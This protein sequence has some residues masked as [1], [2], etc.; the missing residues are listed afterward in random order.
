MRSVVRVSALLIVLAMSGLGARATLA[1]S[2]K[3]SYNSNATIYMTTNADPTFDT[4]APTAF[5]ESDIINKLIFSGVTKWALNGA[6]EGDLATHW[7]VSKNKLV[8]TFYLRK[9][10]KW[11][12]GKPFTSADVVYTYQDVVL[13]KSTPT[14]KASVY[15]AV[16]KVKADG[17]YKVKFIL[18]T[19]FSDLPEYL[20]YYAPVLPKHALSGSNPFTNTHFNKVHPIG[21]GPYIMKKYTPGES[22]TLVRNPH[23]FGA[24]PKIKTI[25]FK[26]IPTTTTE[27]S[28]LL[29]GGLT[30]INLT[31]AQYL[32]PLIHNP[33]LTVQKNADQTYYFAMV[34][35]TIS[36]FKSLKVRKALD[37]AID[38]KA[39]IKALLK[40]YGKVATGPIA[41][42]Q[43]AYYYSKVAQYPYDP[44]K[45]LELLKQAGY[46]KVNGTLEKNGKPF[47]INFTAGQIRFLVPASELIQRYWQA[48]GIKVNLTVLDW[49]TYISTVVVKRDYQASFAW[50]STPPAPDMDSYYACSAAKAG[51]N[52]SGFC[53]PTLD[54]AMN[55]G[56]AAIKLSAQQKAY[57]RVQQLLAEKLPLLYLFYPDSFNVMTK[58]LHAPHAGYAFAIDDISAWYVTP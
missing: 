26:I 52:L 2:P 37:Y 29:S 48:L 8:W 31:D 27:V 46:K 19:P 21:T 14:S 25:V 54:K 41:P 11:Q 22:I 17:P 4:W 5:A 57:N 32:P 53:D 12:D 43:K 16:S 13:N 51:Y 28:D 3:L 56:R 39:M 1:G 18:N 50:W 10:V 35:T 20:A 42:L 44:K 15:S 40:G 24:E 58:K 9:G 38:K 49:N 55:K 23:Y 33:N 47:T 45:A 7:T 30:Y 36:P 6:A 34:N